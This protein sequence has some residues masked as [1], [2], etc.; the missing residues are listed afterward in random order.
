MQVFLPPFHSVNFRPILPVG[1]KGP[2]GMSIP[3]NYCSKCHGATKKMAKSGLPYS[4][5]QCTSESSPPPTHQSASAR[6]FPPS[7]PPFPTQMTAER[8]RTGP[9]PARRSSS[10]PPPRATLPPFTASKTTSWRKRRRTATGFPTATDRAT[11]LDL[12][13]KKKSTFFF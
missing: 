4:A 3:N 9:S 10:A 13:K 2:G 12:K 5:C 8:K 6:A 7:C 1:P 11:L